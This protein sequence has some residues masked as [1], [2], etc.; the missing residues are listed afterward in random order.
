MGAVAINLK[1]NDITLYV[2]LQIKIILVNHNVN[3]Y[4][5]RK[6]DEDNDIEIEEKNRLNSDVGGK[7]GTEVYYLSLGK[8]S[9][10]IATNINN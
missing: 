9:K 4:I 8:R 1:E 3:F 2:V 5:I 10:I 7:N 6:N